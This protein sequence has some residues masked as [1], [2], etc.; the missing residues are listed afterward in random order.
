[1]AGPVNVEYTTSSE[2]DKVIFHCTYG[3]ITVLES[4]AAQGLVDHETI[5]SICSEKQKW[6]LVKHFLTLGYWKTCDKP[7]FVACITGNLEMVK[8]MMEIYGKYLSMDEGL[9]YAAENE[10]TEIM[11]QLLGDENTWGWNYYAK[12]V[13]APMRK[14]W[15]SKKIGE[16]LLPKCTLDTQFYVHCMRD[17][18]EKALEMLDKKPYE[19]KNIIVKCAFLGKYRVIKKVVKKYPEYYEDVLKASCTG[20]NSGLFGTLLRK[21]KKRSLLQ[22]DTLTNL[23]TLVNSRYADK[24]NVDKL[25]HIKAYIDEYLQDF[26]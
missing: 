7:F 1:M 8:Y 23:N 17:D 14:C 18:V 15:N 20:N 26:E 12:E 22:R 19:A 21:G 2:Y 16:Y 6:D 11:P 13:D 4:L 10:R 24:Y 5:L 9:V 3:D 25:D